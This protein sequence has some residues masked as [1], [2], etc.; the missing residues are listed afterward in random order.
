MSKPIKCIAHLMGQ[1]VFG[2]VV[3]EESNDLKSVK[4]SVKLEGLTPGLHGFHIHEA[5]NIENNCKGCCAHFNPYG[6]SHG[7]P[8][9][10]ERHVGDLGNVKADKDGKVNQVFYD[11]MIKLRGTKC[12]IVGR[13]V[14]VHTDEDNLGVPGDSESLKT[15]RAGSRE[16]C[17]V[18]GYLTAYYF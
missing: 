18:I 11:K 13:S 4:I 16:A 2:S 15:G 1:K 14:V 12:N 10:S 7:S 3:F 9:D 17:G 8:E 6:K 5:G